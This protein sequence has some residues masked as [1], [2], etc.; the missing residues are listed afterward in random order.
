[1]SSQ[2][3][4]RGAYGFRL[5]GVDDARELL[6]DAPPAW[7]L[8]E[9]RW[10]V[11]RG[12]A[13]DYERVS[14]ERAELLLA[15]GGTVA[16]ERAPLRAEYALPAA[17]GPGA[18]VHPHL[19]PV[20]AVASRWLG[21]ESFHGGAVVLGDG[22]WAVLGDKEAGKSSMLAWLALAGHAVMADDLVVVEDGRVLAGPRSID[23]REA[24]ARELG[25]GEPLGRVGLRDRW[26][27]QLAPPPPEVPLRGWIVLGWEDGEPSLHAL[28]GASRL[29][30]MLPHRA[31]RLLPADPAALVRLSALPCYELR[32]GRDWSSLPAVAELLG[33][34]AGR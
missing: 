24:S 11:D 7:P 9:L 6:V 33:E 3:P 13:P 2:P 26:R 14:D 17:D 22:A 8:L 10:R 21:R 20:A 19:A 15:A 25:A 12:P 16:I 1:V 30:A 5:L 32:R 27:L 28:R 4:E 31:V 23:L 34:V 29:Q 18:L